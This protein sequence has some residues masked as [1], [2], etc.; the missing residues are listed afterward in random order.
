[1]VSL[2]HIVR[3]PIKL[4]DPA[5]SLYKKFALINIGLFL[6]YKYTSIAA[7]TEVIGD[8]SY[9]VTPSFFRNRIKCRLLNDVKTDQIRMLAIYSL[10]VHK[11]N[12]FPSMHCL[13]H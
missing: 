6:C 4:P 2:C 7:T 12:I 3:Y 9:L 1:M 5:N 8:S 10:C 11:M 13:S